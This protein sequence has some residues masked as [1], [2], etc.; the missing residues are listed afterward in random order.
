MAQGDAKAGLAYQ[1]AAG[2]YLTVQPPAGEHWVIERITSMTWVGTAPDKVAD[3]G[4]E[5]YDGST[6]S[7]LGDYGNPEN[8]AALYNRPLRVFINN[9][10][11][12]RIKNN[13]ASAS[14][15]G[16]SGLQIK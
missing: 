16:Y 9:S 13:S 15:L 12:A 10:V 5:L 6:I 14:N 11:Y 1:V 2:G 4:I 3:V 7:G 8:S